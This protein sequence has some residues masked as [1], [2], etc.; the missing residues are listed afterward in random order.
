MKNR[1]EK[2]SIYSL[3]LDLNAPVHYSGLSKGEELDPVFWWKK[4]SLEYSDKV[5]NKRDKD[6]NLETVAFIL[7]KTDDVLIFCSIR[8]KTDEILRNM[9][10]IS[11]KNINQ[12]TTLN[13]VKSK[14]KVGDT[15]L[16]TFEDTVT[17][18]NVGSMEE[19]LKKVSYSE[20]S[21]VGYLVSSLE[22]DVVMIALIKNVDLNEYKYVMAI[23]K[24]VVK[25]ISVL[26]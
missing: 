11:N 18:Y 6:L 5:L 9:K 3:P 25:S 12:V 23:P 15:V 1:I 7:N 20:P 4:S 21:I 14:P 16:V 17:N 22:D 8:G 2:L 24:D 10:I 13:T 26:N 19:I